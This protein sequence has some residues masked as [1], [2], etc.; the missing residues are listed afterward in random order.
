METSRVNLNNACNGTAARGAGRACGD[1]ARDPNTAPRA[2]A[3]PNPA[4][5]AAALAGMRTVR[6][7]TVLQRSARMGSGRFLARNAHQV[8]IKSCP[9]YHFSS[10]LPV[11]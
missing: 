10:V 9:R 3:A 1:A 8:S 5:A 6:I 4:E 7:G 11:F 2:I